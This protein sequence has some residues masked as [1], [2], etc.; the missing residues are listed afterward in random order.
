MSTIS[1]DSKA[2]AGK[3]D[4]TLQVVI[5]KDNK[6]DI[7]KAELTNFS[8]FGET[9]KTGTYKNGSATI[10]NGT[11]KECTAEEFE[12]EFYVNIPKLAEK[13]IVSVDVTERDFGE[14]EYTAVLNTKSKAVQNIFIPDNE[15]NG[16][17]KM[18]KAELFISTNADN[19]VVYWTYDTEYKFKKEN[20]TSVKLTLKNSMSV[21]GENAT[22]VE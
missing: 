14:K 22:V 13:D 19:N 3:I 11:P 9:T 2:N 5:L 15:E 1:D 21:S 8:R 16:S 4:S 6:N 17:P 10:D 18:E 20:G 7:E 12:K